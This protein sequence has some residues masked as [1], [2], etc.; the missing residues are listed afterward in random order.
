MCA[1]NDRF[2]I[3]PYA[4][5]YRVEASYTF[6]ED[7]HLEFLNAHMHLRGKDFRFDATYPDGRR[8]TL[9]EI[10]GYD[11]DWQTVYWLKEPKPI[12]RGTRIDCVAHFDNSASNFRNPDPSRAVRWSGYTWDEMMV[13]TM[14]ISRDRPP[15]EYLGG[16]D[17][18]Q[19]LQ[20]P[21]HMTGQP[22]DEW[23]DRAMFLYS[24][25]DVPAAFE[26]FDRALTIYTEHGNWEGRIR[27]WITKAVMLFNY[28]S[29]K[30]AMY[31][32]LVSIAAL[33]LCLYDRWAIAAG[34][35]RPPRLSLQLV[36]F[37]GGSVAIFLVQYVFLRSVWRP[38]MRLRVLPVFA[39]QAAV[40]FGGLWLAIQYY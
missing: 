15:R 12:P 31:V 1:Y 19:P 10:L 34:W 30:L 29:G 16:R 13:G 35:W 21:D 4:E 24:R 17:P 23:V 26:H 9:L 18:D 2:V 28:Y 27:V 38:A 22:G 7:V 40:A 25:G 37:I 33:L 39:I 8:E 36:S 14:G 3:P 32:A 6:Q 20:L 5:N 11:Y